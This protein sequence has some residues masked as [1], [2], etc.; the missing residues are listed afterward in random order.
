MLR[1]KL[2]PKVDFLLAEKLREQEFLSQVVED[3][4]AGIQS[5]VGTAAT[6]LSVMNQ[7]LANLEAKR[8]R[9]R[10]HFSTEPST[11]RSEIAE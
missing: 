6:E 8:Q 4:N 3:F 10:K 11:S 7:K 9:I 2:E 1:K 5:S